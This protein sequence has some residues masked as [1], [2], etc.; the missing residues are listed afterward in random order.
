MRQI[1][2]IFV[3]VFYAVLTIAQ[4]SQSEKGR[5]S[6]DF[7]FNGMYYIP[8]S[9]IGAEKVDSKVR[10]NAFLNLRFDKGRFTAGLR[11][12]FFLFPL[13]DMEKI[14]YQGQGITNFFVNYN[15]DII[16]VSAG[17]FYEQ[18]GNG[19]S[20]R[21]YEDRQLGID[22]SLL[23]ARV[24]L[25][26]YRGIA[27]KAVFGMERKNFDFNYLDRKDFVR[28]LDAEFTF[29]DIFP[30]IAEKHFRFAVGG[31]VVSKYEKSNQDYSF[32][33]YPQTD[34]LKN[35]IIPANKI[36]ANVAIWASRIQ[37]GYKGLQLDAEYA[38]KMND[39]N[40]S[41]QYIYKNGEALFLS[42]SY[43]MK[44][45][46]ISGSFIQSDNMDWRSMR[47]QKENTLLMINYIPAIN[48]QYTYQTLSSYSFASQPNSEVGAQLQVNYQIPKKTKIGGKYGTD[49][50][51]NYSRFH[52]TRQDTV[53]EALE[54]GTLTG[55]NGYQSR[56]FNFGKTLLYQDV[57]IEISRR[58]HKNWKLILAYNYI[59]YNL[60]ILQGHGE[61][62]HGHNVAAD[63][64]WKINPE[65]A[66]RLELQHLYSKDDDGSWAYAL[67]EYSLTKGWF[68]SVSDQWNYGNVAPDR[69]IHYY[70]IAVAYLIK[71][72]RIALN[73]GKT[74]EGIL[75]IGGVCRSV[76]ASYGVGLSV[77]TT[78]N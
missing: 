72:T 69:Q 74:K 58:L 30:K 2:I 26:P 41:N 8:D 60:E 20:F 39:P 9:I 24:K 40:A 27:I 1:L 70:N 35:M 68:V 47:T 45:L 53:A 78:I 75:C 76:P 18:F 15:H 34:S 4:E 31:S 23:G 57:G 62:F 65:N 51:F 12:E 29:H 56:L 55:T 5:I 63:L 6:G 25:T 54:I 50:T 28:G 37:L 71:T 33:I 36:P 22:N 13:L 73:F 14:G 64:T 21:A 11:Y 59:V 67:L 77:T 17:Y 19:L 49:I 52:N 10:G 61:M 43:S 48:R 46:G 66:L 7:G 38:N 32:V 3:L 42:L 44:G 16:Q